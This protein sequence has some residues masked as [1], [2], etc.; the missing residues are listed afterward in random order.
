M[1][2]VSAVTADT[3]MTAR[4]DQSVPRL[5]QANQTFLAVSIFNL[6]FLGSFSGILSGT[7]N[8]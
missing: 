5:S 2:G 6:T 3:E 4:H 7:F 1:N 8:V